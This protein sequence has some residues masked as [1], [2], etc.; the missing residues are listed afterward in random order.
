MGKLLAG[1]QKVT[2]LIARSALPCLVPLTL[3]LMG[4]SP[5]GWI[6]NSPGPAWALR[7]FAA[8]SLM[9]MRPAWELV[10]WGGEAI[11]AEKR[12]YRG[13][14]I[15][16]ILLYIHV[17]N[18]PQKGHARMTESESYQTS[19]DRSRVPYHS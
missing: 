16:V 8:S 9:W 19:L 7:H 4:I 10:S 13:L 3:P 17:Q 11:G 5:R 15:G 1:H 12:T 14:D 2:N 18:G 6:R